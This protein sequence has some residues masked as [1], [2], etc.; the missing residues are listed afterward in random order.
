MP[1]SHGQYGI[2]L[3]RFILGVPVVPHASTLLAIAVTQGSKN[4]RSIASTL[5]PRHKLPGTMPGR[6]SIIMYEECN[7]VQV[8]TPDLIFNSVSSALQSP[9]GFRILSLFGICSEG[10]HCGSYGSPVII[11]CLHTIVGLRT[12]FKRRSGELCS[13]PGV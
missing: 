11:K 7:H 3:L 5:V 6:L 4:P 12:L 2:M 8:P 1:L 10:P 13:I 9:G